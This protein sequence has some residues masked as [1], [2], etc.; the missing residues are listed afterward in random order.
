[1]IATACARL[2]E[3]CDGSVAMVTSVSHRSISA[4][5]R[6]LSS[7]PA[8]IATGPWVSRRTSSAAASRG[9]RVVRLAARSRPVSTKVATQSAIAASSD[10]RISIRATKSAVLWAMPS[11]RQGSNTSGSTSRMRGIPK[12]RA[13]RTALAMLTMSWGLTSTRMGAAAAAGGPAA[14]SLAEEGNVIPL[15]LERRGEPGLLDG[16]HVRFLRL[17]LPRVDQLEQGVVERHHARPPI[18]LHDRG[19]LEGLALADEVRHGRNREQNLPR[20]HPAAADLLAQR[21]SD[22]PPQRLRQHDPHL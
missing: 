6:P 5:V 13:M 11:M 15:R 2:S 17:H 18:R 8:T 16:L 19:N 22:H 4:L 10:G 14:S 12:F 1:M 20:R 9:R 21:L 3:E 7:R